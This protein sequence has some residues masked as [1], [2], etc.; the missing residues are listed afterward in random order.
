MEDWFTSM[1]LAPPK[2]GHSSQ[3]GKALVV[4]ST[5]A[6]GE[7]TLKPEVWSVAVIF[8]LIDATKG[9]RKAVQWLVDRIKNLAEV[10][11]LISSAPWRFSQTIQHDLW[12]ASS[13]NSTEQHLRQRPN[14][15][16]V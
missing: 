14:Q 6:L 3:G 12:Q 1:F 4:A 9:F 15:L 16:T 8:S 13:Q 10:D 7:H 2:K 5:V 11:Q